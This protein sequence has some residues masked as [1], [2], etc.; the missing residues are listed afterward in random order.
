MITDIIIIDG[1]VKNRSNCMVD[2]IQSYVSF[3]LSHDGLVMTSISVGLGN[4]LALSSKIPLS[5]SM[6]SVLLWL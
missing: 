4:G 6:L 2:A 5:K 1:S 3:M